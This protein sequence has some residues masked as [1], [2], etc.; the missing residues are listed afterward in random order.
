[1]GRSLISYTSAMTVQVSYMTNLRIL[2]VAEN[3]LGL[4]ACWGRHHSIA[5]KQHEK[6]VS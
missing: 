5:K 3:R 4:T 1:M 6:K 2:S